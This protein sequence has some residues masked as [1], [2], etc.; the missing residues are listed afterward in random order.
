M[1]YKHQWIE[2]SL[3]K[4]ILIRNYCGAGRGHLEWIIN[5]FKMGVYVIAGLYFCG[6]DVRKAEGNPILLMGLSFGFLIICFFLGWGWD[7]IKGYEAEAEFGNKRN[8]LAQEIR[9]KLK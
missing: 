3:E 7:K 8:R 1:P 2:R 9:E 5:A 6:I 4:Y